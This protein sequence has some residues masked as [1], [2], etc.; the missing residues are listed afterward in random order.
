M[1]YVFHTSENAKHW[2]QAIN[3]TSIGEVGW[4]AEEGTA[5]H[6]RT[7]FVGTSDK[8]NDLVHPPAQH[9]SQ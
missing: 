6:G 9:G 3:G 5:E 7:V 2:L 4:L 8:S 1:G